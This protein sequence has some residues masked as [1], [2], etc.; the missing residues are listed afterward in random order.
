[1]WGIQIRFGFE[2]LNGNTVRIDH[3]IINGVRVFS[4]LIHLNSINV[5]SGQ[6][7]YQRQLIGTV[8]ST[9]NSTGPHLHISIYEA[10]R[11]NDVNPFKYILKNRY[12]LCPNCKAYQFFLCNPQF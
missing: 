10:K 3:G 1:M 7:V 2:K 11:G 12:W 8:G 4:T 9:G 5:I 6:N